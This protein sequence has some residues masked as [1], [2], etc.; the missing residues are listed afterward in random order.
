MVSGLIQ[1][2]YTFPRDLQPTDQ[3]RTNTEQKNKGNTELFLAHDS[4]IRAKEHGGCPGRYAPS[5][6]VGSIFP[7]GRS[8]LFTTAPWTKGTVSEQ[9]EGAAPL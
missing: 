2:F 7:W 6:G 8:G 9:G 5:S 3:N 1:T 4:L